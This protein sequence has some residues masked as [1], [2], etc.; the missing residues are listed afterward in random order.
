MRLI[1]PSHK[2]GVSKLNKVRSPSSLRKTG[3]PA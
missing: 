2:G 1:T 3:Y